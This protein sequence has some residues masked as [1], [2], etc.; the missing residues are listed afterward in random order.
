MKTHSKQLVVERV[1]SDTKSLVKNFS[2]IVLEFQASTLQ[3][4]SETII[5]TFPFKMKEVSPI[6]YAAIFDTIRKQV[7]KL[8]TLHQHIIFENRDIYSK[9]L[10]IDAF[11][12]LFPKQV[13]YKFYLNSSIESGEGIINNIFISRYLNDILDGSMSE[14]HISSFTY[15]YIDLLEVDSFE[16]VKRYVKESIRDWI[17]SEDWKKGL[18]GI[19]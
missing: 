14:Q 15:K 13:S 12:I 16:K 9:N 5:Q 18:N 6:E 2:D 8:S 4:C 10:F 1:N 17:I 11:R 3:Y 7:Y 19:I